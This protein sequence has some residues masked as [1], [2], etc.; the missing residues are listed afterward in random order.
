MK[1]SNSSEIE[2]VVQFW[3]ATDRCER[4]VLRY[5]KAKSSQ[6]RSDLQQ[7]I[8]RYI[9]I[10]QNVA[11][12][13]E[14]NILRG[15]IKEF[16]KSQPDE[17]SPT[18]YLSLLM[19]Y[20]ETH[21]RIP[22]EKAMLCDC[23][24]EYTTYQEKVY[25]KFRVALKKAVD[26]ADP[27]GKP[28]SFNKSEKIRLYGTSLDGMLQTN[29]EYYMKRLCESAER[30]RG[31]GK[32]VDLSAP[33]YKH[34]LDMAQKD[35]LAQSAATGNLFGILDRVYLFEL[36]KRRI[37]ELKRRGFEKVR[38]VAVL[39]NATTDECRGLNGRVFRVE[40]LVIG[41]NAP[42]IYPPPHPCRSRLIGIK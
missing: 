4:E 12:F 30:V 28:F 33:A 31:S 6:L 10:K 38:F 21:T 26:I 9:S 23:L 25:K 5:M 24:M 19:Y 8:N 11:P 14:L 1:K 22:V 36:G 32:S 41:K 40:D 20:V 39:D 42:P 37:D 17:S 29:A 15:N 7:T 18:S 34:I 27:N 2:S 3:N 35:M 16:K 13:D